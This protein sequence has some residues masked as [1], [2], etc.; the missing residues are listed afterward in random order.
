MGDNPQKFKRRQYIVA[1]AFQLKYVGLLLGILFIAAIVSAYVV[2][3]TAMVN[4]GGKL[5]SVYPQGRLASIVSAVNFRIFLSFL[6]ISPIVFIIG[7]LASHRIAGPIYRMESFLKKVGSGD[8]RGKITLRQGD[9]LIT[10]AEGINSMVGVTKDAITKKK[11][12]FAT[13]SRELDKLSKVILEKGTDEVALMEIV[14]KINK[15]LEGLSKEF[16]RYKV[17]D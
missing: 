8:L 6:V 11:A 15:E 14:Q 2:Y 4:M 1:P 12:H 9:E 5:A 17:I 16:N 10:L 7:I 3:Y 13:L